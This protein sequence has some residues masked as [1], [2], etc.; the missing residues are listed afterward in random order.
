MISI[1]RITEDKAY[2]VT[3][4]KQS[5]SHCPECS[6]VP[7]SPAHSSVSPAAQGEGSRLPPYPDLLLAALHSPTRVRPCQ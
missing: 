1:Q 7:G 2:H 6:S 5:C 3:E 4:D